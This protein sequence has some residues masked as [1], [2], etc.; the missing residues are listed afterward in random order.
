MERKRRFPFGYEMREGRIVPNPE[1]AKAVAVIFQSFA[2]GATT[3]AIS[4]PAQ[5]VCPT[6]NSAPT[7]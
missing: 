1:E 3:P 4:N 5:T 7:P 2:S 6:A